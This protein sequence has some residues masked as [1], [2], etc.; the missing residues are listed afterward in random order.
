MNIILHAESE[1][2]NRKNKLLRYDFMPLIEIPQWRSLHHMIRLELQQLAFADFSWHGRNSH[3]FNRM[4][5]VRSGEGEV[6][7]HSASEHFILRPG[8]G[9]FM[10]GGL[11]LEFEFRTGLQF[12]SCHFTLSVLPGV[13][14][15]E[16]EKQ[17]REFSLEIPEVDRIIEMISGEPEWRG[18]C[19]VESFLWENL[20]R[21]PLRCV[22]RPAELARL[23][24][25]YGKLLEFIRE[26]L[27]ARLGIDE[28]A[29]VAGLSRGRLSRNFSRDFAIPLKSFLQKELA[30]QASRYLLGSTCSVREI[31]E[32]LQ[33]SS[34]YYF[35]NFFRRC[36]GFSPR[37]FR[38]ANPDLRQTV[39][40]PSS[41]RETL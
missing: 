7:N 30:A 29:G 28:L 13:D 31:S 15:F 16:Q 40:F 20:G 32:R 3:F 23:A 38:Q 34:E 33:F 41:Q 22:S 11:D 14:L 12:F 26:N 35:S 25:R 21:L 6:W 2:W 1:I 18:V 39:F 10:P 24:G 36:T 4:F 37:G 27:S 19:R 8:T 9:L 17:C 5:L